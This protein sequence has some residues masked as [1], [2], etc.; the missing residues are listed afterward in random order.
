MTDADG[1]TETQRTVL[2]GVALGIVW[3]DEFAVRTESRMG[4]HQRAVTST[5]R[6]LHRRDLIVPGH[7]RQPGSRWSTWELTAAG[8]RVMEHGS[9]PMGDRGQNE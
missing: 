4:G 9:A 8:R 7:Q 5:T 3:R 6:S 2:S 1:L